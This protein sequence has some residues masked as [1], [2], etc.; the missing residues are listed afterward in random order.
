MA[1]YFSD[2]FGL[3]TTPR[4]LTETTN[5]ITGNRSLTDLM[6]NKNACQFIRSPPFNITEAGKFHNKCADSLEALIGVLFFHLKSI[7]YSYVFIIKDW[8]LKNTR[9]AFLLRQY[10]IHNGTKYP[11]VYTCL[12]YTSP[13]PR[14]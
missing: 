1:L 14:D 9:L 8:L 11:Y 7:T 5:F 2:L 6:I 3:R 12:L 13:S 10:L 4:F